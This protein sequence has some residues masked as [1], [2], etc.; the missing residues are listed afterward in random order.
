ME[1]S[2][3]SIVSC[4]QADDFARVKK[5]VANSI[6]LAGGLKRAVCR[7]HKVVVKP[8]CVVPVSWKTGAVT[9]PHVV[10][11]VCR[12]ALEA[13][14]KSVMIAEGSGVGED[15]LAAFQK[16]GLTRV[17]EELGIALIDLKKEETV[18]VQIPSGR[19]FD[20]LQ[21][22]RI[23]LDADV[24]INVPVIKTHNS[25]PA[26]LGL[27]NI[28]GIIRESDKK[29]FHR[30][31]LANSIV[32]LNTI[33]QPAIT[34]L[35]GSVGMEGLG[36]VSGTPANLG[37][38]ISSFDTVAADAVA[39]LVI[40]V[41]PTEI[42][43]IHLAGEANLGKADL[44]QI[45]IRGMPLD[46]ARRVFRRVTLNE[47]DYR[48]LGV[49]IYEEGAC[50]G[51]KHTMEYIITTLKNEGCLEKVM[52]YAFMY[53]QNV[54][55]PASCKGRLIRIGSCTRKFKHGESDYIDGCPPHEE[56]QCV[57]DPHQ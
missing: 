14:A 40:G 39:A 45:E 35:D 5:A 41:D 46:Q 32:D 50:S 8:N 37:L 26:T 33:V 34:V 48:E 12:L 54:R 31:G 27:K 16:C 25:F 44:S 49:E 6:E 57:P 56:M 24:I 19:I 11:A 23:I 38:I 3:V 29:R 20:N 36:P 13:G 42:E 22:P 7:G 30:K 9:N 28:K 47:D 10:K 4:K 51:C 55:P 15:T 1:K 18:A 17:A 21:I 53:G 2:I 52:P 43:Y